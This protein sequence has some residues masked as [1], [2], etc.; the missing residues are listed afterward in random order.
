MN[1]G[2]AEIVEGVNARTP[3]IAGNRNASLRDWTIEQF[4]E[5]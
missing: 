3:A 1:V 5:P 4:P 2:R